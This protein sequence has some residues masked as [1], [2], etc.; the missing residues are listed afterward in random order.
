MIHI[1]I[2]SYS[3]SDSCE[4]VEIDNW[5]TPSEYEHYNENRANCASSTKER[6]ERRWEMEKNWRTEWSSREMKGGAARRAGIDGRMRRKRGVSWQTWWHNTFNRQGRMINRWEKRLIW[7]WWNRMCNDFLY[8]LLVQCIYLSY[9]HIDNYE[10]FFVSGNL[11]SFFGRAICTLD[12]SGSHNDSFLVS[13]RQ[14]LAFWTEFRISMITGKQIM[15]AK[16]KLT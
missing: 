6:G 10:E 14:H 9:L 13:E 7:I 12:Q 5:N 16:S 2:P 1:H 4:W 8:G 15:I 11:L 3:I